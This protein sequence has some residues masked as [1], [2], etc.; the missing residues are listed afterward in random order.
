MN[1]KVKKLVWEPHYTFKET[2]RMKAT[3]YDG[4]TTYHVSDEGWWLPFWTL[5]KCNGIEEAKEA[6]QA[7]YEKGV[8]ASIEQ[9]L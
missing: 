3:T 1:I 4:R 6:T 8:L 2:G 5:T 9:V 7:D